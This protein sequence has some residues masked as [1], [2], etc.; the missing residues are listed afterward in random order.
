MTGTPTDR[1]ALRGTEL[2]YALTLYLFQHGPRRVADLIDALDFQGFDI[3]G[4]AKAVSDALRWEIG[5]QRVRRLE[6]GKYAP[7]SMPRATEHRIYTRV[8]VLRDEAAA[9]TAESD[10]AFWDA[11]FGP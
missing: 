11:L 3:P 10:K 7:G 9:R 2:R 8:M 4:G 6:R 5:H 1:Y